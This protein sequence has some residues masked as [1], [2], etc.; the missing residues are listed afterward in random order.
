MQIKT[1]FTPT[2]CYLI[3]WYM[4]GEPPRKV[5]MGAD[6][7]HEHNAHILQ[8]AR[9]LFCCDFANARAFVRFMAEQGLWPPQEGVPQVGV[10]CAH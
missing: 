8:K 3:E 4:A 5:R 10:K 9:T 1:H 6:T 2:E 7:R